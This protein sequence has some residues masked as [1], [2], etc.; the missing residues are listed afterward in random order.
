M[1]FVEI[2]LDP[3]CSQVPGW[4]EEFSALKKFN[5]LGICLTD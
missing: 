3:C 1:T 2:P 5:L 4:R